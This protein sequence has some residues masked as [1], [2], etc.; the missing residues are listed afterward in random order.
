MLQPM[1]FD[2]N[3]KWSSELIDIYIYLP[4]FVEV[5]MY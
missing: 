4:D 5:N 2:K 1:E 3:R